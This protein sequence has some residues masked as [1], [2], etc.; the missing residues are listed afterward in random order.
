MP[1]YEEPLIEWSTSVTKRPFAGTPGNFRSS[2]LL[3]PL[4]F[5]SGSPE[6]YHQKHLLLQNRSIYSAPFLRHPC[7]DS[8][9]YTLLNIN[10]PTPSLSRQIDI[11]WQHYFRCV[12]SH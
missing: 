9:L 4:S 12:D 1:I 5:S 2:Y 8:L 6:E 7:K 3:L 11:V 10:Q